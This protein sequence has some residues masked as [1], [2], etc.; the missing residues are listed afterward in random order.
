M[1]PNYNEQVACDSLNRYWLSI[2]SSTCLTPQALG[3]TNVTETSADLVWTSNAGLWDIEWG[4]AGFFPGSGTMIFTT[5]QNPYT[6]TGLTAGYSYSY[7]VRS[8]CGG[9]E[10][11]FWAGP[12]TFFVPCATT[13]LPYY[14]DF[15][16]HTTYITPHCWQ[17]MGAGS[18]YNWIVSDNTVSGGSTPDLSFYPYYWFYGSRSYIV[19][20]VINTTGQT[21]LSLSFKQFIQSNNSNTACELWTT[22]DGGNTWNSV[23]S[24]YPNN[25]YGPETTVLSIMTADVGSPN[26]Q[27]AFAVNGTSSDLQTW[28]IDDIELNASTGSKTLSLKVY[29]EGLYA[30]GGTMN[31]AYDDLGPHFGP[32]IADQVNVELHSQISYPTIVYIAGPVDLSTS[33]MIT[34]RQSPCLVNR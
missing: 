23:W 7:Y 26:F 15:S 25:T 18:Y 13:S 34:I 22:S 12:Y 20:P 14:E 11:S 6:L 28:N 3:V 5:D 2:T 31:Q 16:S 9:S 1:A 27:F 10:F 33:G 30:G 19:S 17:Q 29:L 24:V 32:G 4:N 8:Y 21:E